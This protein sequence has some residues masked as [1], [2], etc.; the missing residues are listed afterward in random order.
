MEKLTHMLT[1]KPRCNRGVTLVELMVTISIMAILLAI[2]VPAMGRFIHD[3]RTSNVT[4]EFVNALNLARSEAVRRNRLV[5]VCRSA[6]PEAATPSCDNGSDWSTGWV[7]FVESSSANTHGVAAENLLARHGVLTT[8]VNA[9]ATLTTP[10]TFNATGEPVGNFAGISFN[11]N[12]N[13]GCAR[14]VAISRSGRVTVTP[15]GTPCG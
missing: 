7:V 1:V 5:T 12:Y 4:N 15:D 8:N 14:E 10:V 6:N 13:S 9:Q 3:T 11:F 2:G